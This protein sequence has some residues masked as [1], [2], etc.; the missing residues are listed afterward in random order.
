M[1]QLSLKC[2][3]Y[4]FVLMFLLSCKTNKYNSDNEYLNR[5]L[6]VPLDKEQKEH[7]EELR[8]NSNGISFDSIRTETSDFFDIEISSKTTKRIFQ[9]E[10]QKLFS[11]QIANYGTKDLFL[12][13]KFRDNKEL[14]NVELTIEIF[15]KEKEKFV[16]YVQKIKTDIFRYPKLNNQKRDILSTSK[17]KK[18]IYE[19]IL[20]DVNKKIVDKGFYKAKIYIDLS[21]FGY[22]KKLETEVFFEVIE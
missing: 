19:N 16:E 5:S 12:P 18:I 13:E 22:F 14:N 11:M 20:I 17:G 6:F 8:N 3:Y 7:F 9:L 2:F 15:K 21:N 1:Q 4:L 10:E